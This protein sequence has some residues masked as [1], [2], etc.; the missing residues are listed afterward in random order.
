[1]PG[2]A[3][4]NQKCMVSVY[5][6]CRESGLFPVNQKRMIS[7]HWGIREPGLAPVNTEMHDFVFPETISARSGSG[8]P[9]NP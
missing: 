6:R 3:P 4:V 2:L 7:V 8:E 1:M 5:R 9:K